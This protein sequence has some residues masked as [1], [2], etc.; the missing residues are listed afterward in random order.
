MISTR[1]ARAS[2]SLG[3]IRIGAAKMIVLGLREQVRSAQRRI[4]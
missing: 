2:V 3:V 1:T 4:G